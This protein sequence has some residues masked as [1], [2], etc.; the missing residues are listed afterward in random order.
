MTLI[1]YDKREG[2]PLNIAA[3]RAGNRQARSVTGVSSTAL[4]GGGQWIVSKVALAM[5][6]DDDAERCAFTRQAID[7][8][9]KSSFISRGG[10]LPT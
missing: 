6:L 10:G 1:P 7:L 4:V 5:F 3:E 2:I 9:P 8:V